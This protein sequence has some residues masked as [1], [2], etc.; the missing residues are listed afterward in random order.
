MLIDYHLHN[1]FSPD[2]D[3]D[4]ATLIETERGHGVTHL[5]FTNHSEWFER[6]EEVVGT[7]DLDE[8]TARFGEVRDEIESLR[9]RFPDM[10]LRFGAEIQYQEQYLEDLGKFVR[11]TPF[12]FILGSVHLIDGILISGGKHAGEAF[13]A[14]NEETAYSHYFESMQKWVEWGQF[15][16][17]AH[18]DICKKFGHLHYGPF[19]PI[20]YESIIKRILKTMKEKGIG[21]ELNAGSLH[22]NCHELFPHP[23][24][25]KWCLE[26]GIEN[27]T[28]GSDAHNPQ[29]AGLY[30]PE[31]LAIAKEAGIKSISTYDQRKP[32]SHGI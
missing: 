6:H 26:V 31:V 20:K 21:I 1:H 10:D 15:D 3:S 24:I 19:D 27:Y 9:P 4:T 14:M 5:C 32:T 13:K 16:A 17:V 11:A 23:Q 18:F 28:F 29:H 30:M 8:A 12:D 2:S 25:L 22:K 7:F